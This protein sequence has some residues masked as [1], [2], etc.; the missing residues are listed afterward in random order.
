MDFAWAGVLCFDGM[1][2]ITVTPTIL[3]RFSRLADLLEQASRLAREL[4]HAKA[5]TPHI[6]VLKRPAHVPKDEEWFWSEAWQAGEQEANE[7]LAAGR[8]TTFSKVD[9]AL[10]W[11]QR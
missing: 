9:D 8:L 4:S 6:P 1:A 5:V 2:Q 3:E 11:L 7:D 10:R